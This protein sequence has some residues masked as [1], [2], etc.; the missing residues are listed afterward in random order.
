MDIWMNTFNNTVN[1]VY[2]N[3]PYSIQLNSN[4]FKLFIR[5]TLSTA[6][7]NSKIIKRLIEEIGNIQQIIRHPRTRKYIIKWKKTI[8]SWS[9]TQEDINYFSQIDITPNHVFNTFIRASILSVVNYTNMGM[10][11]KQKE[12]IYVLPF[13]YV[14]DS[15]TFLSPIAHIGD[16]TSCGETAQNYEDISI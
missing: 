3:L 12:D 16:G 13:C 9:P 5:Y 4:F 7:N 6:D 10:V 15:F 1:T 11:Y 2:P 14:L 8:E